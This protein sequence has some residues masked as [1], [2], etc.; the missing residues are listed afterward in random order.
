MVNTAFSGFID[1]ISSTGYVE[2]WAI[3]NKNNFDA[4]PV[5]VLWE[6]KPIGIGIA[7]LFRSDLLTAGVGHGWHAF[8]IRVDHTFETQT[9]L[10]LLLVEL[11]TTSLIAMAELPC[12][13][14]LS[15]KLPNVDSV[16]EESDLKVTDI[17]SLALTKTAIDA[18]V[19]RY[20]VEE[21]VACGY[22]YILGRPA[23]PGGHRSYTEL[24]SS[25]EMEPLVFLSILFNS[26]ERRESK[27]P[28]LAPSDSGFIFAP[29]LSS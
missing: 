3:S 28:V 16:L 4:V 11:R 2:G 10:R 24:I 25:G 23:D 29:E 6:D 18:F 17:S 26:T 7:N 12:P 9:T 27:W 8:R 15:R 5:C 14:T 20:G 13:A 19:A 22:C 21:F 1:T